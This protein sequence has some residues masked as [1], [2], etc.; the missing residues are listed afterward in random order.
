[1]RRVG[2][3]P[4]IWNFATHVRDMEQEIKL[5]LDEIIRGKEADAPQ[6]KWVN[7]SERVESIKESL[8]V[9]RTPE[10]YLVTISHCIH[11]FGAFG[12]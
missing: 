9:T 4:N 6:L 7:L 1:M 10:E 2:T 11:D 8:F 5:E 3:K 12:V